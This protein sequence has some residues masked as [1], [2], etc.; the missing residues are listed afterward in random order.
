M[1]QE[2]Y[3]KP[4]TSNVGPRIEA[5]KELIENSQYSRPKNIDQWL[6][7]VRNI[8]HLGIRFGVP[9]AD[10]YCLF[11]RDGDYIVSRKQSANQEVDPKGPYV[12]SLFDTYTVF[13][14]D[15]REVAV[16]ED[17]GDSS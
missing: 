10:S 3:D 7:R 5:G 2:G 17:Y 6:R 12:E 8:P 16:I 14:V 15:L 4:Y 11:Y 9:Q 1:T 13:P